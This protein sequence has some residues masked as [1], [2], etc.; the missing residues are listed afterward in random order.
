MSG[1]GESTVSTSIK[2]P[3]LI[4]QEETDT[5]HIYV[6]AGGKTIQQYAFTVKDPKEVVVAGNMCYR[7]FCIEKEVI[8]TSVLH[9]SGSGRTQGVS[10]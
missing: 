2:A 9:H 10:I 3:T 8:D 4:V 7:G 1:E 6:I 5:D